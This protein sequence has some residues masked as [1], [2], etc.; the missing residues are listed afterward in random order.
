[1]LQSPHDHCWNAAVP[2]AILL[3]LG[4]PLGGS[5]A[6]S[7]TILHGRL[8]AAAPLVAA[9][10]GG[11]YRLVPNTLA[12]F[13]YVGDLGVDII[14]TDLRATHDGVPV[15]KHDPELRSYGSCGGRI[16][17]ITF[18][19]L[20]VCQPKW[21]AI[22]LPTFEEVL[23][24]AHGRVI[25]N[26]EFKDEAV[27]APA[28][29]LVRRYHAYDWVYFQAT[30]RRRYELA[31]AYDPQVGLLFPP[32]S[33]RQ[34]DWALGLHDEHLEVVELHPNL[35]TAANIERI[36]TAGKLV[37]ENAWH[38]GGGWWNYREFWW[39]NCTAAY[40]AGID[41]AVSENPESC[42]RERAVVRVARATS[43]Q[44]AVVEP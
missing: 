20:R 5:R 6:A 11:V 32:K 22:Q 25:L 1:M 10:R 35:R 40:D 29:E 12:Q 2:L 36:H 13:A 16:D 23:Q 38:F 14:E 34:L 24:Q 3:S 18:E 42:L 41:I 30:T 9:H 28:I 43:R 27:I 26:A 44:L 33:Q 8:S 21:W 17:A 31:R 39:A 19:A 4:W 7:E 37:S 15:V